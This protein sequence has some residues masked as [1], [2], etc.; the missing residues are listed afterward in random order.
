MIFSCDVLSC[1]NSPK[2]YCKCNAQN[3]FLCSNH[4][5]QHLDDH[6]GSDHALKSMFSPIPQ[7]KKKYY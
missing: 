7:E 1:S 6:E 5:L 3:R 2:Y 4:A